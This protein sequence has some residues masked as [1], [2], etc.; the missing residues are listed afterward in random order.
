M[1]RLRRCDKSAVG[2]YAVSVK[3]FLSSRPITDADRDGDRKLV[4][5]RRVV[6]EVSLRLSPRAK[7]GTSQGVIG[8][9]HFLSRRYDQAAPHLRLAIEED[10]TDPMIYRFLAACYAHMG[11]LG[12]AREVIGRLRCVTDQLIPDIGNLRNPEH[13]E[14]FLSG[15]RLAIAEAAA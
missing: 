12:D 15:L 8:T 5:L 3:G 2:G 7:V 4:R 6:G 11:R 1:T 14:L 10:P 9:S 13:R